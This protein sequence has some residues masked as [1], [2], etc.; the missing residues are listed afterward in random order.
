[1]VIY[2]WI[3]WRNAVNPCELSDMATAAH[4]GDYKRCLYLSLDN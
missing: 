2:K 1:M 3:I 4:S